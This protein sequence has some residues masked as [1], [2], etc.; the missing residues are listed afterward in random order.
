[1]HRSALKAVR[2]RTPE[3]LASFTFDRANPC[4]AIPEPG[5]VIA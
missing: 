4:G 1:M 2:A 5:D 3:L